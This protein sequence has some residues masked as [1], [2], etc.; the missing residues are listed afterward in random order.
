M[1]LPELAVHDLG[2][3]AIEDTRAYDA[4]AH[5][6]DVF[7]G[8]QTT[9]WAGDW[10][11]FN[12]AWDEFNGKWHG[13]HPLRAVP[14]NL[15]IDGQTLDTTG[16]YPVALIDADTDF[17]AVCGLRE[18]KGPDQE[19]KYPLSLLFNLYN[20]SD[21]SLVQ[22]EEIQYSGVGD[23][24]VPFE[25]VPEGS[26]QLC[27]HV[28]A[29]GFVPLSEASYH[30]LVGESVSPEY[31]Y[32]EN[33]STYFW[34]WRRNLGRLPAD[35]EHE[36]YTLRR[37]LMDN[38]EQLDR[39]EWAPYITGGGT[40]EGEWSF[41]RIQAG[42]G[43]WVAGAAFPNP[44]PALLKKSGSL[45]E[46]TLWQTGDGVP[47]DTMARCV[48]ASKVVRWGNSIT[49]ARGDLLIAGNLSLESGTCS[50]L[51]KLN[52]DGTSELLGYNT[53]LSN[54]FCQCAKRNHSING[55]GELRDGTI[56]CLSECSFFVYDP[57]GETP[58]ESLLGFPLGTD[59]EPGG[60]SLR[61]LNE[62]PTFFTEAGPVSFR[63]KLNFY[64]RF[65]DFVRGRRNQPGPG[66]VWHGRDCSATL[67]GQLWGVSQDDTFAN[68]ATANQWLSRMVEGRWVR[69]HTSSWPA[70]DYNWKQISSCRGRL[71]MAGTIPVWDEVEDEDTGE[72]TEVLDEDAFVPI[73]AVDDGVRLRE[74][75]APWI[76][77][78]LTRCD[79]SDGNEVL[80]CVAR[81]TENG[82]MSAA[83]HI[84]TLTG[85]SVEEEED[86][87]GEGECDNAQCEFDTMPEGSRW[88]VIHP[89][90]NGVDWTA[91][92]VCDQ[93]ELGEDRLRPLERAMADHHL[94]WYRVDSTEDQD[95]LTTYTH[96]AYFRRFLSLE[97]EALESL[98]LVV[99]WPPTLDNVVLPAIERRG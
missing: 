48:S 50:A 49:T 29:G 11:E 42:A 86:E 16:T 67:W 94:L 39:P 30:S 53:D 9:A 35:G 47:F 32:T 92:E 25:G 96:R 12:G 10:L 82:E 43:S 4:F 57:H 65:Q 28:S 79:D 63:G 84:V 95:D 78:Y 40:D 27:A 3:I 88:Q 74:M 31:F 51:W 56:Y 89:N 62:R 98:E 38:H 59:G 83:Q 21:G 85:L 66:T 75:D 15:R 77:Q 18:E 64:N 71:I 19:I 7:C 54:G 46:A 60:Y 37:I 87:G 72:V 14:D 24:T 70:H 52:G 55:I 17:L 41:L 8:V 26:Y 93:G 33:D 76:P 44:G 68:I 81:K 1:P 99:L 58:A 90:L 73:W 5:G 22:S 91:I 61:I 45:T 80:V 36:F 34:D 20:A 6:G 97:H 23:M 2:T 69:D 13:P